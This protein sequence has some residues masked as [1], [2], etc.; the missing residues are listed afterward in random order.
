MPASADAV[1]RSGT[2][3][4]SGQVSFR[5]D[6]RSVVDSFESPASPLANAVSTRLAVPLSNSSTAA[7][8]GVA[9][10][11]WERADRVAHSC[12]GIHFDGFKQREKWLWLLTC[13][14]IQN[15]ICRA[16]LHLGQHQRP[17]PRARPRACISFC[18]RK[19]AEQLPMSG[20]TASGTS[21]LKEHRHFDL[22]DACAELHPFEH[23]AGIDRPVDLNPKPSSAAP[24]TSRVSH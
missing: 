15:R 16:I 18:W 1:A 13:G 21:L 12:V 24:D 8:R 17:R 7:C 19:A 2:L 11:A 10:S 23:L 5:T 22:G 6:C 4:S 3:T 14:R 20:R 9:P